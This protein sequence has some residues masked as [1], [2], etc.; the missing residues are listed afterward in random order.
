MD[1]KDANSVF[2]YLESVA[3]QDGKVTKAEF[4]RWYEKIGPDLDGDG[5]VSKLQLYKLATVT[6]SIYTN[7]PVTCYQYKTEPHTGFDPYI[8]QNKHVSEFDL[9][10]ITTEKWMHNFNDLVGD[11]EI[12]REEFVR[13]C[14]SLPDRQ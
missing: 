12:T 6:N 4:D 7:R 10:C 1:S 8:V 2:D 9:A 11:G 5:K 3:Q 14:Q 13:R